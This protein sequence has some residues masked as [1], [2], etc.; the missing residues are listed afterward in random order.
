MSGGTAEGP[1]TQSETITTLLRSRP[2]LPHTLSKHKPL[3]N[4]NRNCAFLNFR[5][6]QSRILPVTCCCAACAWL[7]LY[8]DPPAAV[9]WGATTANNKCKPSCPGKRRKR[10]Q[11]MAKRSHTLLRRSATTIQQVFGTSSL[12][13]SGI[14]ERMAQLRTAFARESICTKVEDNRYES[15]SRQKPQRWII[16]VLSLRRFKAQRGL[17]CV[18]IHDKQPWFRPAVANLASTGNPYS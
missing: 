14:D 6:T 15:S 13:Q 7:N 16:N 12:S 3:F 1:T 10:C 18:D 17:H 9:S 8:M 5:A 2:L 11:S 4:A